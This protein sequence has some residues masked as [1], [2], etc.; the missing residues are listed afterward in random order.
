MKKC[1]VSITIVA[2]CLA[3]I[4]GGCATGGKVNTARELGVIDT[5]PES[6][7]KGYVEFYTRDANGPVFIYLVNE[8]NSTQ[9]LAGV[10][11]A[12][13]D[14]YRERG[15]LKVSERLRVAAPVGTHR[16]AL[17]KDGSQIDVPVQA[18]KVTCVEI[19]YTP[20]DPSEHFVVY[21]M[22]YAVKD[23]AAMSDAVGSAPRAE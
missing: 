20:I 12:T 1:V 22:D 11:V 18:N 17:Q 19:D 8:N 16:F 4:G 21:K 7:T 14:K 2:G 15:G 10:G 5:L 23:P 9:P 6:A 13:G 3:W